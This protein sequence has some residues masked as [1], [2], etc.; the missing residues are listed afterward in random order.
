MRLW[1]NTERTNKRRHRQ[2]YRQSWQHLHR[3]LIYERNMFLL[4]RGK[5]KI[6]AM[7]MRRKNTSEALRLAL[8]GLRAKATSFF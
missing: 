4:T 5:K 2:T 3:G 1:G 6:L 8:N 7:S